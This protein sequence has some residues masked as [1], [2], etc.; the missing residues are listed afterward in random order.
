MSTPRLKETNYVAQVS[1]AGKWWS[2]DLTGCLGTNLVEGQARVWER[3]EGIEDGGNACTCRRDSLRRF[4]LRADVL[5][6]WIVG[7]APHIAPPMSTEV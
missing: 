6:S 5:G 7:T 2:Q 4:S 1:P 3:D